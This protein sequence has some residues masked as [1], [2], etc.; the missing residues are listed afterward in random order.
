MHAVAEALQVFRIL[1]QLEMEPARI[2]INEGRSSH[3]VLAISREMAGHIG[4]AEGILEIMG[5]EAEACRIVQATASPS[6]ASTRW[7]RV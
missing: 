5:D 3:R 7:G 6:A 2:E 1:D 4:A